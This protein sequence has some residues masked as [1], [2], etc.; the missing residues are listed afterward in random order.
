MRCASSVQTTLL[1]DGL[2]D[3]LWSIKAKPRPDLHAR[4]AQA[5]FRRLWNFKQLALVHRSD[6]L[7]RALELASELRDA[8]LIAE[9]VVELVSAVRETLAGEERAPGVAVP[10]IEALAGLPDAAC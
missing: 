1:L 4:A 5:A 7:I 3:L 9:T 2:C 8:N 10:M 6:S